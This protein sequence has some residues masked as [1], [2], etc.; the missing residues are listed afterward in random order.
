MCSVVSSRL[1]ELVERL[2]LVQDQKK[3]YEA[4]LEP[5]IVAEK[6]IRSDIAELMGESG[7]PQVRDQGMVISYKQ[8]NNIAV[9]DPEELIMWLQEQDPENIMAYVKIDSNAVYKKFGDSAPC[10]VVVTTSHIAVREDR[11]GDDY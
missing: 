11:K 9:S 4:L 1:P 10:L 3:E 7:I 6:A 8:R 5:L 2:A